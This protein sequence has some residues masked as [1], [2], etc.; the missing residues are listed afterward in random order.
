MS[1]WSLRS[2]LL[3]S[4]RHNCQ[5][6]KLNQ[7][8][9]RKVRWKRQ[10]TRSSWARQNKGHL[11]LM[12]SSSNT[13]A[14]NKGYKLLKLTSRPQRKLRKQVKQSPKFGKL[15]CPCT[16]NWR[17]TFRS[18]QRLSPSRKCS[19]TSKGRSGLCTWARFSAQSTPRRFRA[20]RKR[21]P[22]CLRTC[23]MCTSHLR[24]TTRWV[25]W[26]LEWRTTTLCGPQKSP[27]GHLIKPCADYTLNIHLS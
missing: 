1:S 18:F 5:A 15:F 10:R 27:N 17:R 20:R 25:R 22:N 19:T 3:L 7:S 9:N 6:K 23:W 13:S 24:S 26:W 12:A 4:K 2:A 14:T 21:K 11:A 16:R 8:L